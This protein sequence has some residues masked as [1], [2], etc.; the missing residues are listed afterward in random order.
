MARPDERLAQAVK[1]FFASCSIVPFFF[2]WSRAMI[3]VAVGHLTR[4]QKFESELLAKGY[5]EVETQSKV[6]PM[7][8][9]KTNDFASGI[10]SF[11]LTW[12]D[13]NGQ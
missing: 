9:S 3:Q 1:S 2:V 6:G 4:M 12:N 7:E 5:K 11:S 10:W 13:A 8:Y